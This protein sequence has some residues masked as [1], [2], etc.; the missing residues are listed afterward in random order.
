MSVLV[1]T[2]HL[3]FVDGVLAAHGDLHDLDLLSD[4]KTGRDE[5]NSSEAVKIV[6][7]ISSQAPLDGE[8]AFRISLR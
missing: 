7:D 4:G 6:E 5:D 2:A 1:E 3:N 8:E